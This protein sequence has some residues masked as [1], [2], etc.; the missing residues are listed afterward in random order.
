VYGTVRRPYR[1]AGFYEIAF[2][3]EELSPEILPRSRL[4]LL[5]GL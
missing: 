4:E 3:D 2:D 1:K 5:L